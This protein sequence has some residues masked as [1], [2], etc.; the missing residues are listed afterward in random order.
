LDSAVRDTVLEQWANRPAM[1]FGDLMLPPP[2]G[3]KHVLIYDKGACVGFTGAIAGFRRN[4][5]AVYLLGKGWPSGL[6]G[7]SCI[8]ST[9]APAAGRG[10]AGHPHT[11]PLDVMEQ[12]ITVCPAGVIADPCAGSGSTLLAAKRLGHKSIGVELEERYC[13][14]AARRLDQNVLP[15]G[16]AS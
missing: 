6:G 13:E 4:A 1:V 7:R 3:V 5:E 12:L 14:I 9:L 8:V 15:F 2:V 16:E 10:R 11:K